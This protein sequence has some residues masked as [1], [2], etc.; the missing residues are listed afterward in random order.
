MTCRNGPGEFDRKEGLANIPRDDLVREKKKGA[1]SRGTSSTMVV[2]PVNFTSLPSSL[3]RSLSNFSPKSLC[4]SLPPIS[5]KSIND[6]LCCSHVFPSRPAMQSNTVC[7][8]L[9]TQFLSVPSSVCFFLLLLSSQLT[10]NDP[11]PVHEASTAA[12]SHPPCS[13]M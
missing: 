9:R 11:S 7:R 13:Q 6:D 8:D 2:L 1:V 5:I 3:T 12:A 10:N 4:P